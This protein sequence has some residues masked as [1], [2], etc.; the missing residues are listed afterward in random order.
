MKE[1][2]TLRQSYYIIL[3]HMNWSLT[4]TWEKDH[5]CR[6]AHIEKQC[7][8][9]K[10]TKQKTQNNSAWCPKNIECRWFFIFLSGNVKLWQTT[11]RFISRQQ[12][13]IREALSLSLLISLWLSISQIYGQFSLCLY[14]SELSYTGYWN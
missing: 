3:L 4:W 5:G 2:M 9:T 7:L 1:I 11:P 12:L 6:L 8:K 13:L 10:S 14:T